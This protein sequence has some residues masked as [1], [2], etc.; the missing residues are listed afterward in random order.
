VSPGG[1]ADSSFRLDDL[2]TSFRLTVIMVAVIGIIM[3]LVIPSAHIYARF[4][5]YCLLCKSSSLGAV[6]G[7]AR[8]KNSFRLSPLPVLTKLLAETD[9]W[10][11]VVIFVISFLSR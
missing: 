5:G 2:L 10:P 8:R 4:A 3:M 9:W 6:L 11:I 7:R 1:F